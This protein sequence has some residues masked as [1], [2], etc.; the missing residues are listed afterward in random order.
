MPGSGGGCPVSLNLA[1]SRDVDIAFETD[2]STRL[3]VR[4]SSSDTD[5]LF[6]GVACNA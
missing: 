6:V 5:R 1:P 3:P 4:G 2:V